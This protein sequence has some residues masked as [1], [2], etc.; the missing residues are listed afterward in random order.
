MAKVTRERYGYLWVTKE[1][2]AKIDELIISSG[3]YRTNS[4][5]RTKADFMRIAI[6]SMA[7]LLKR[8]PLNV[9]GEVSEADII[10]V[11]V[12]AFSH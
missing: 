10:D 7:E 8:R 12:K 1:E 2:Q 4:V 5:I 3:I 9:S 11:V 6:F